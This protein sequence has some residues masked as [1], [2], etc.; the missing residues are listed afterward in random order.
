MYTSV[1]PTPKNL[2]AARISFTSMYIYT[3]TYLS[4]YKS[5]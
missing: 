5:G 3:Y 2:I 1:P 4:I